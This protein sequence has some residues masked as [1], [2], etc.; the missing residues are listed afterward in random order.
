MNKAT[1]DLKELNRER[2]Q[3]LANTGVQLGGLDMAYITQMLEVLLGDHL[4]IAV[5]RY[6]TLL[7]E[8]L[9][10]IEKQATQSRLL[11]GVVLGNGHPK[12]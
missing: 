10:G 5:H 6:E 4:E 3:K 11:Q 12:P 8:Q 9:D 2:L 1:E 7:S